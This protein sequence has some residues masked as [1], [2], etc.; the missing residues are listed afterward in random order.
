MITQFFSK[1]KLIVFALKMCTSITLLSFAQNVFWSILFHQLAR[2]WNFTCPHHT[3]TI[4]NKL[5]GT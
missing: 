5:L 2:G 3:R 4:I 1:E